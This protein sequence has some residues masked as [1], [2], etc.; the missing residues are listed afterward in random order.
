MSRVPDIDYELDDYEIKSWTLG[1][2]TDCETCGMSWNEAEFDPHFNGEN[3]W[4]FHYRVGCFDGASLFSSDEDREEKL[5]EM[6][7]DLNTFPGW[8]EDGE[9]VVRKMIKEYDDARSKNTNS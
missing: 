1:N 3:K 5:E 7:A 4:S 8:P 6:F 2:D 9:K